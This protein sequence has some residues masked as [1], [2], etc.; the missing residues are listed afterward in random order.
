[1]RLDESNKRI[2]LSGAAAL[3]LVL[4]GPV[5]EA[6]ADSLLWTLRDTNG[7]VLRELK[8]AQTDGGETWEWVRDYIRT[9]NGYALVMSEE[10]GSQVDNLVLHP[11]HL[12]SPRVISRGASI[13]G[14][15][16]YFPYGFSVDDGTEASIG[17]T[18][19]EKDEATG[20]YNM[21]ARMYSQELGRFLSPDA[22]VGDQWNRY[23]YVANEPINRT[24][25][26]GTETLEGVSFRTVPGVSEQDEVL[27]AAKEVA[28]HVYRMR[29]EVGPP[30]ST[31]RKNTRRMYEQFY[32][33]S[34]LPGWQIDHL[35]ERQIGGGDVIETLYPVTRYA[36]G[37]AGSQLRHALKRIGRSAKAGLRATPA[38][39]ALVG[40][41][42]FGEEPAH[43]LSGELPFYGVSRDLVYPVYLYIDE[44]YGD[45]GEPWFQ[46]QSR[47][48]Q[49]RL[50]C[51]SSHINCN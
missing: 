29:G 23:A 31:P 47:D 19:H 48:D 44:R 42:F 9:P 36:N 4:V 12:G 6:V 49:R 25:P 18:G 41:V 21:G 24:D 28:F 15:A 1:M 35:Y 40:I 50:L 34:V 17:F 16:S 3:L 2:S 51:G 7:R 37:S 11:D 45:P 20:I 10:D 38:L 39:G 14:Q 32:G 5:P 27:V 22:V 33:V 43:A 13:A 26:N 46:N 30:N 8:S